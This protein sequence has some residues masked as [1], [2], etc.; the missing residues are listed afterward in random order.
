ML[1]ALGEMIGVG[2]TAVAARRHGEGAHGLAAVAA[3]TTLVL[4][5]AERD[6]VQS[7]VLQI[8]IDWKKSGNDEPIDPAKPVIWKRKHEYYFTP[9]SYEFIDRLK[10][11][12]GKAGGLKISITGDRWAELNLH[13]LV[14][15]DATQLTDA[16]ESIRRL[17]VTGN[18][19]IEI[20]AAQVSF[21]AGQNLLDWLNEA[22]TELK[23]G[24]IK[25]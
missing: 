18:G 8:P 24:E 15:L 23:T 12:N 1:L 7:D 9:E 3:G 11:F 13:E 19:Q 21:P 10:R 5:Y 16:V 25:Q 2:L 6:G 14:E 22:K 4:A 17:P 20:I